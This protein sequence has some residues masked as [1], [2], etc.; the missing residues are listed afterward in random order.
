[1]PTSYSVSPDGA[2]IAFGTKTEKF[3]DERSG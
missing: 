1:M 2:S 3:G